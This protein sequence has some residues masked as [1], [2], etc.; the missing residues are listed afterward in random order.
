M[1]LVYCNLRI[2]S[3]QALQF[4]CSLLTTAMVDKLK[5]KK[6]FGP[7]KFFKTLRSSCNSRFS[8]LELF[9]M[10]NCADKIERELE[11][12]IKYLL[13]PSSVLQNRIN[14]MKRLRNITRQGIATKRSFCFAITLAGLRPLFR[15]VGPHI[16]VAPNSNVTFIYCY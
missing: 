13:V 2:L 7:K 4:H 3:F 16:V 6:E 11:Y 15:L 9:I 14:H 10:T 1:N 12:I 5:K 8:V